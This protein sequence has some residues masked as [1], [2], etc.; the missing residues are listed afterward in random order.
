MNIRMIMNMRASAEKTYRSMLQVIPQILG[1]LLLVSLLLTVIPS[2]WYEMVFSGHPLV[3]P[4]AGAALGSI[5]AGNPVTSY[6]IGGELLNTGISLTAVTAF[7][8]AWVTVG[9]IQLPV[10]MNILGKRFAIARNL[11]G[12]ICAILIAIATEVTLSVLGGIL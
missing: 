10:E 9:V 6:I 8:V 7:I 11:C 4:I 2:E 12:F 1:I 3:D 5:A